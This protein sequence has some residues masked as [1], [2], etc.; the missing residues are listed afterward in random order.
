MIKND[1]YFSFNN[2]F[3]IV[4]EINHF[5]ICVNH[6]HL[7]HRACAGTVSTIITQQ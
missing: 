4:Y 2:V 7:R 6:N 1:F 3:R 5:F